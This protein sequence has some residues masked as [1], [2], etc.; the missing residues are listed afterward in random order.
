M[1]RALEEQE[2]LLEAINNKTKRLEDGWL[3]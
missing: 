3:K 2:G 1:A